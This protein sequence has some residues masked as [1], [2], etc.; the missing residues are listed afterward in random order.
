M[1][2]SF[3]FNAACFNG[4]TAPAAARPVLTR[5]PDPFQG[6]SLR[7]GPDPAQGT[8]FRAGPDPRQGTSTR[9]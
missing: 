7:V 9:A 4:A 8:S 5:F 1:M 6:T 3:P 2:N